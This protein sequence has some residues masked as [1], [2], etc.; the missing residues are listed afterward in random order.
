M[1]SESAKDA[2][3]PH[4]PDEEVSC[5]PLMAGR[6]NGIGVLLCRNGDT[7]TGKWIDDQRWGKGKQVSEHGKQARWLCVGGRGDYSSKH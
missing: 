3:D 6:R 2:F 4:E 5:A 1:T 7:Y